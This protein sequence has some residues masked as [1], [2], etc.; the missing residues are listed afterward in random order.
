MSP[1]I[2]RKR[3]IHLEVIQHWKRIWSKIFLPRLSFG[4]HQMQTRSV[5]DKASWRRRR[6]LLGRQS[7]S[8]YH[9]ESR[10][11]LE[12]TGRSN[13]G[14]NFSHRESETQSARQTARHFAKA[15]QSKAARILK[16]RSAEA[17]IVK[18]SPMP[19]PLAPRTYFRI[20]SFFVFS[21]TV[22][23]RG[24]PFSPALLCSFEP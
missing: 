20:S 5:A 16:T 4:P 9:Q 2:F 14:G 18:A 11:S 19:V 22:T 21:S 6:A 8:K 7:R 1:S 3:S 23:V 24:P 15:S 17:L 13:D 12:R 10:R